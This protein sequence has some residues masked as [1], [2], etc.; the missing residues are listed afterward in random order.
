MKRKLSIFLI[1]LLLLGTLG[2][3]RAA[4]DI[5]E[6]VNIA[7][8]G[9]PV[10]IDPQLMSDTNSGFV[11]SFYT[12]CLYGYDE[13]KTLIPVL[14]ESYEVSDD[15]LTYTFHLKKDL[16]WSDGRPLTAEDF[17]FG[18]YRL[19]DPSVGSNS[20]YLITDSCEIKN[21]D[22]VT[23]G[24]IPVNQLGVSA[25][26]SNTVV[27]ELE[28]PCPYFTALIT[29]ADFA[30][31]NVDFYHS[32]GD[33]YASSADTI[34]SCGPYIMDRYEPLAM[35][36]HFTKN[37]NYVFA[38]KITVSGINL[39]VVANAQQGLMSYEAGSLDMTTVSGEL[40]DLAEG[41]PELTE[42]PTA[43]LFYLEMNQRTC[44]ALKNKNI[45]MALSKSIDRDD[46][47]KNVLKTG[48]TP[49]TRVNPSGF[50][51]D[52]DGSD[53]GGEADRYKDQAGY[54]PAKAKELWE[55]GLREIGE[56]TVT[57]S[58]MFS[59]GNN[60]LMEALKAQMEK[61]LPGLT[62]ELKVVTTKEMMSARQKGGYDLLFTGWVADYADPTAFLA[63]FIST[64]STEGYDNQEYDD[65]YDK[66]QD[67]EASKDVATRNE[68][69]HKAEDLLMDDAALIPL[70]SKGESYLIRK[71]VTG[72]QVNPTGIGCIL[73][74]LKKEVK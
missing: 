35:Q 8:P 25:P 23:S 14:A 28:K 53:F 1:L 59:S 49:I 20:V 61:N 37:P 55:Q 46:F 15:G 40:T 63:L 42:F 5:K 36:I 72:F 69:M 2:G 18:F 33:A 7:L 9:S 51:T 22:E 11:G 66:I 13:E 48:N 58:L 17:V 74:A 43:S 60:N 73:T 50:Y 31:C 10:T 32:A 24:K 12:S 62:V 30:P 21:A 45:R 6:E 34:L 71:G 56:S 47:V 44:P 65:L 67:P 27:V 4:E 41:D 68:L 26:D 29:M 52:T 19:A 64:G 70:F 57:L 39:Q 38:D 16:K 54:D 3:C